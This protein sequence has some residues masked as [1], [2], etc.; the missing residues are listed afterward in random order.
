MLAAFL[1]AAALVTSSWG[2]TP[3]PGTRLP[4][5]VSTEAV[6]FG[7]TVYAW[8]GT[9]HGLVGYRSTDGMTFS[10][11]GDAL[12]PPGSDPAVVPLPKGGWR[13]YFTRQDASGKVIASAVSG[14]LLNWTLDPGVRVELGPSRATGVP[15]AV[16][17][18][19]GRVRLYYV[20]PGAAGESIDSSVSSDGLAF[21]QESGAR[22]SGGYVDPA[23]A[24]LSNGSWLM[25]VSTSPVAKQ[26]LFVAT[27]ADGLEW[28]LDPK[29]V[30]DRKDANALDPTLLP[31]GG[32]R[33][34]VYYTVAALGQQLTGPHHVESGVLA[35]KPA[36]KPKPKKKH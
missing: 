8:T 13:M 31:L 27:S 19:D 28:K 34:R 24:R 1:A 35:R 7:G 9:T 22:L 14:D 2:F 30:L 25:I 11:L 16:V 4:D 23:V 21:T 20:V 18:P 3:D 33:F 36:P 15:D 12:L 6:S 17:L 29:P 26:R 10:P 32:D 5:G